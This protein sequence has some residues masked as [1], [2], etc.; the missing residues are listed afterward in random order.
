MDEGMQQF[1]Q[2]LI[3]L[4]NEAEHLLLA[5]NQVH[6]K[7]FKKYLCKLSFPRIHSVLFLS[8]D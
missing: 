8:G 5:R 1:Q 7:T 3:E 2:S 6:F 4:E